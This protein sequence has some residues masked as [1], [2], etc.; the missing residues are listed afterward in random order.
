MKK[1]EFKFT[2]TQRQGLLKCW[3]R[4]GDR[5]RAKEFLDDVESRI[6]R[7]LPETT[8]PRTSEAKKI[9]I[10]K[11]IQQA[12]TEMLGALND[13]PP[14][15]AELLNVVWLRKAYGDGYFQRHSEACEADRKTAPARMVRAGFVRGLT[16]QEPPE[17]VTELSKLPPDFLTQ[18]ETVMTFL[19]PL[20]D[21]AKEIEE[22]WRG[23][24]QWQDKDL[25]KQLMFAAALDYRRHF[26]KPPSPANGSSFRKFAAELSKILSGFDFG[27]CIVKECCE[28]AARMSPE[29]FHR[30]ALT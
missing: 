21:A 25:E 5:L 26:D 30:N 13:L 28:S 11:R 29:Y 6:D 9:A 15:V 18:V 23:S 17:D 7:W 24:K 14:D 1:S 20:T 8:K 3:K 2:D 27:A 16:G 19:L 22:A 4:Q 12:A 10:A